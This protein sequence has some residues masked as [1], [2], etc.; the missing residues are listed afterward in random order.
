VAPESSRQFWN[1]AALQVR[2][3][4]IDL[5]HHHL[6]P[7][8][9]GARHH[10]D[11]QGNIIVQIGGTPLTGYSLSVLDAGPGLPVGFDPAQCKSLGMKIVL[12]LA[13]QI[14]GMV[15]FVPGDKGEGTKFTV[16]F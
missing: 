4:L 8:G 2:R 6:G 14:G 5:A 7:Q 9:H 3:E 1:L 16:I 11:A 10:S 12:A 15:Q 13:K